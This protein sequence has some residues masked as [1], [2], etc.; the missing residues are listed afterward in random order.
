MN[1]EP[2]SFVPRI[3]SQWRATSACCPKCGSTLEQL[4]D[5]ENEPLHVIRCPA[6]RHQLRFTNSE[7]RTWCRH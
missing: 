5:G 4:H 1:R 6:C 7:Q 3:T 2:D